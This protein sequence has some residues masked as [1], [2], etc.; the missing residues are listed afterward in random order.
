MAKRFRFW[1]RKQ[2]TR[3]T[4]VREL[5]EFGEVVFFATLLVLGLV[6]LLFVLGMRFS[7]AETPLSQPGG[8]FW[9]VV[10]VLISFI[11]LGGRGLAVTLLKMGTSPERRSALSRQAEWLRTLSEE[12]PPPFPSVPVGSNLDNS[13]GVQLAYRLPTSQTNAWLLIMT[14]TF[15]VVWNALVVILVR[16]VW[17]SI[18][19]EHPDW[20]ATLALLPFGGISAWSLW[21]IGRQLLLQWAI[22]PTQVEVSQHPLELGQSCRVIVA[23]SGQLKI[24]QLS[25]HFVCEERSTYQQG[26][27]IRTDRQCVQNVRLY[28]GRDIAVTPAEPF[29]MELD[30]RVPPGGMHSFQSSH[31]AVEWELAVRVVPTRWAPFERR[32]PLI[33]RPAVPRE[34]S[35]G[36][37]DQHTPPR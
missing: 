4:G 25:I 13:P 6:S 24:D 9:L 27:D 32:F 14:A 2:G 33:V 7:G 21:F 36:T 20:P 29:S 10:I 15:T 1:T 34:V 3:T 35:H 5:G 37:T 22:G 31:N 18:E 12:E 17:L 11:L 28:E 26:T 8:G 30:L 16:E 19:Q 23:Q